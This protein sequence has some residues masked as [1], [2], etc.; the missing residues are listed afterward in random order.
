MR[1]EILLRNRNHDITIIPYA[2][3]SYIGVDTL[4]SRVCE[5]T[6][7]ERRIFFNRLEGDERGR[8]VSPRTPFILAVVTMEKGNVPISLSP[9]DYFDYEDQVDC[10]PTEKASLFIDD[11]EDQ[12]TKE[13][14][15]ASMRM[16][17]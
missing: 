8:F 5:A 1:Y 14:D 12:Y 15:I 13:I 16:W 6:E 3:V 10:Y 4:L 17:S 11:E 9:N 7:E 2:V